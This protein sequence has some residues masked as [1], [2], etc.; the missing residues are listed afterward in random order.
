[1]QLVGILFPQNNFA[2]DTQISFSKFSI[3]LILAR[4]I[5]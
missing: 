1:M 4:A 2:F 5:R 3:M